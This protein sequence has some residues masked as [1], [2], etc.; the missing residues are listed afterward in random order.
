MEYWKSYRKRAALLIL[1]LTLAAV[2]PRYAAA[3]ASSCFAE[4]GFCIG[5]R[6]AQYWQQNGG[7]PVFGY[8]ISNELA[9]GGRIV[10]YF[11]R[12]RFELHTENAAPYDV[13][14]GLLGEEVLQQQ[15][16]DWQTQPVSSGPVAGCLWFPET[17]HNVCDQ[18]PGD[19]F[20]SYWAG[21]GLEFDGRPGKRYAE[22]LALFGLPITEPFQSYN[23]RRNLPGAVVR[24]CA[25]RMAPRQP[26]RIPRAARP[27]GCRAAA[28]PT[29]S[30]ILRGSQQPGR[31]A[32]VV[33]QRDQSPGV[34][35]RLQLLGEILPAASTSSRPATLTPPASI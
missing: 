29:A 3:Q 15:G 24:A 5:G 34:C 11:E 23:R 14:L 32:G 7:L 18:Q 2:G 20:A 12:Q 30:E 26:G 8:P 28:H 21:H 33:L 13:L 31:S 27:P 25:L 10:Q 17:R 16:I 9:E 19:G 22:S 35:A 6:F 4:T 1:L